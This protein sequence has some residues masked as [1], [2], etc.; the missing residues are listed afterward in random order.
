LF[1]RPALPSSTRRVVLCADDFGL[2]EG[3]SRG[4]LDLARTRRIS[5]VGVMANRPWWR[6]LAP[7]LKAC[8]RDI[9]I[10]LHLNLTSGEPLG[11]MPSHAPDGTFA[12]FDALLRRSLLGTL[13]GDEIRAEIARQLS[14]FEAVLGRPPDFVDGHQ[15]VHALPGVR[16]QLLNVLQERR[17]A[18]D[19][20]LRDPSDR[21]AAILR[22]G[23]APQKALVVKTLA[24]GFAHAARR[25]GFTVN[26]GFSGFS[27]FDPGR[28]MA[29][30]FDAFLTDLGR[31]PMVMCHPG[32][33]DAELRL[34]DAVVETREQEYAYL[35]SERF[36]DLLQR[37]A[38]SLVPRPA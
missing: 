22:R 9:G 2:T 16:R 10:G 28:D 1:K 6:Q 34:L 33:V 23:V 29:A 14:A 32:H 21:V 13:R 20:W 38:V 36:V 7:E 12:R 18:G 30:D 31:R 3:V 27:P 8:E 37:K 25:A 4:I 5:A 24:S 35:S 15:H 11:A 19:P 26:E 17:F